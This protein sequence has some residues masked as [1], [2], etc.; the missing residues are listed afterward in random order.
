MGDLIMG[1]FQIPFKHSPKLL[2]YPLCLDN[3]VLFFTD[4]IDHYMMLATPPDLLWMQ[5]HCFNV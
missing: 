1:D 5:F 3:L 2:K 4:V